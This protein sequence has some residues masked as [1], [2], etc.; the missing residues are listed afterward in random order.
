MKINFVS[1][2]CAKNLVDSEIMIGRLIEAGCMITQNP[3]DAEIIIVNTC[4]FIESAINESVDTILELAEYKQS[5]A[6]R[7]LIVTGC[8]P[9]RFREDIVKSLPEVDLFLGVGDFDK[10]IESVKGSLNHSTCILSDPD[11]ITL[12]N[13]DTPRILSFSHLAY[14]KIAEGCNRRCSYCIIPKIRGKQKSR[15]LDDIVAE[16]GLLID[17]QIKELILVAQETTAYGND[18][19]PPVNLVRLL[20]TISDLSENIWIR[21]LYGYP[22]SINQALIQTIAKHNNICSYFDVPVQHASTMVL[23]RMQRKY[24]LDDLRRLFD[25]IRQAAPDAALRT[26][27]IVGFPG[28]TDDDFL[29]L[30]D[31]VN[32][33][34]F[35]HLGVFI[36]SDL[37]D[38]LSHRLKNHVPDYIAKERYEQ[39]MSRQKELSKQKN[40]KHIGKTYKVIVEDIQDNNLYTGRTFFQAP[41]VDGISY[42]K[43]QELK[44]GSFTR[45]Q[46]TDALEYDLIGKA[47]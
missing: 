33:V 43:A 41:E 14:I 25:L 46:I 24:T 4:S 1:L 39:I 22:E 42:I 16:A 47:V 26:T 17:S 3:A 15:G 40:Q 38:L 9:E 35:D 36:Y 10:I 18:L 27:V 2:G 12:Q 28:E 23:K 20:E 45:V 11:L 7:Q 21:V 30:Y 37:D 34:C 8:L 13:K 6:C 31:F 44:T 5:G 19:C 32:D 29:Q